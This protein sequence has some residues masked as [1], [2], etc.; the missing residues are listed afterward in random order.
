MCGAAPRP[1]RSR[2]GQEWTVGLTRAIPL[3]LPFHAGDRGSNPH[4]DATQKNR[5]IR[6]LRRRPRERLSSFW[7]FG[8][9]SGTF[10]GSRARRLWEA[11]RG[12]GGSPAKGGSL[13]CYTFALR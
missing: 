3:K 5:E 8:N 1:G 4:R 10:P 12:G 7:N 9:G 13:A 2:S 11:P 6:E